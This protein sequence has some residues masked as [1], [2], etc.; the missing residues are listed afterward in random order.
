[1]V[2]QIM[3]LEQYQNIINQAEIPILLDVYGLQCGP[4]KIIAPFFNTLSNSYQNI[5]FC[6]LNYETL[7]DVCADQLNVRVLPTFILMLNGV[8]INRMSGCDK[9]KL[10]NMILDYQNTQ[11]V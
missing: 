3:L 10:V 4:C 7:S 2:T 9:T 6:K 1:M 11:I 8:V 5:T